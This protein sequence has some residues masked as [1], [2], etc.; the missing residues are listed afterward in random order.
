M[1]ARHKAGLCFNCDEKFS[2]GHNKV[3][4]HLFYVDIIYDDS[5]EEQSAGTED[6]PTVSLHAIAGTRS[7]DTMRVELRLG[8]APLVALIDTG[9]THN[10]VSEA[11]AARTGLEA[12]QRDGL[13][14]RVANGDRLPC[15]GVFSKANF[16]VAGEVF[17]SDFF[18]LPLAGYDVV[19]GT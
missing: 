6:A 3:C 14:V 16:S 12:A 10:F 15:S 18:V 1:D 8:D 13:S 17:A 7:P 4:R 9:S 11:A 19:M 2:R 5:D